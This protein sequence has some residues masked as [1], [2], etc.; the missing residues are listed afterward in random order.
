MPPSSDRPA[1]H[2]AYREGLDPTGVVAERLAGAAAP[3]ARG[4]FFSLAPQAA[5]G[6]LAGLGPFDPVA[7]P[8]WGLHLAIE[9]DIDLAGV[10]TTAAFA[11]TPE[12]SAT[13]VPRLPAAGFLCEPAALDGARDITRF[14]G[15]RAFVAAQA[16]A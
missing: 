1:L 16:S 3:D 10:P 15:W 11:S 2:A 14:G 6:A 7:K 5:S 13:A 9:D 8:L 4:V 12:R